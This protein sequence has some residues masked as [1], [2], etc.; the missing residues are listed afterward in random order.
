LRPNFTSGEVRLLTAGGPSRGGDRH[1]RL[2]SPPSSRS[3][4]DEPS[5]PRQS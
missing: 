3:Q 2:F 4:M 5:F 1:E